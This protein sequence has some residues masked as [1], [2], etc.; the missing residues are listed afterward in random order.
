MR[1]TEKK[2]RAPGNAVPPQTSMLRV[3]GVDVKKRVGAMLGADQKW[4]IS[5]GCFTNDC[6]WTN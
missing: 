6:F 1:V 5:S 3:A 2:D 4:Y